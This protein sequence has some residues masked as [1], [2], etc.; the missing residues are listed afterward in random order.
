[1]DFGIWIGGEET[2]RAWR[3]LGETREHL[4]ARTDEELGGG[5]ERDLYLAWRALYVAEASDWFWWYGDD[6]V[7]HN[8]ADFDRLFRDQL[9]F[10]Y[11]SLGEEPPADLEVP[12]SR[13][14]SA[15]LQFEPP[16]SLIQPTIDGDNAF[17][18]E[19]SGAGVYR[20]ASEAGSSS[21]EGGGCLEEMRVG[22]DLG[23]LYVMIQPGPAFDPAAPD[24]R[25]DFE[26]VGPDDNTRRVEVRFDDEPSATVLP[27]AGR[28]HEPL[29]VAFQQCLE[30]AVSFDSLGLDS[31]D[32]FAL[33]AVVFQDEVELE[34][35]PA[36]NL[37]ELEVPD[38][39]FEMRHWI[40]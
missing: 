19:W 16:Q 9:R 34:R 10:V 40:V 37:L 11:Q 26:V 12:I 23:Y 2:N 15:R 6:F 18:Y 17:F 8:D 1:A 33:Q 32:R 30:L 4:G 14:G 25:V 31:G 38:E 22:F 24:M 5:D 39:T 3:L 35:H 7:S 13:G 20:S 36:D 28:T 29:R 21:L 27:P